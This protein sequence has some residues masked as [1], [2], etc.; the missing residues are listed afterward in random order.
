M[1]V[2]AWVIDAL[3]HYP[4]IQPPEALDNATPQQLAEARN[5]LIEIARVAG[6]LRKMV[7]IQLAPHLEGGAMRYGND[8][9]RPAGKGRAKVI[10]KYLWWNMVTEAVL[11]ADDPAGLLSALYPA[12]SLR[13][14]ALQKMAEVLEIS[15]QSIRD[16][17][18]DY[19][20]PTALISVMP[21]HLAPK[22]AQKLDE[23]Q[24]SNQRVSA[25]K[26]PDE[27]KATVSRKIDEARDRAVAILR[28]E[29]EDGVLDERQ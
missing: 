20:E 28:D 23:G 9:L 15:E 12:D 1:N 3:K 22:W 4:E 13:L 17:M 16:T 27:M 18:I 25:P 5:R 2:V 7:D 10:D 21:M 8:L 6:D 11:H 26:S 14:T 19:D 24:L 29:L